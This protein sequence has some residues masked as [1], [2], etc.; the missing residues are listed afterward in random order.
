MASPT[1]SRAPHKAV[2]AYQAQEPDELTLSVGDEVH[3]QQRQEDGWWFGVIVTD[4]APR[5]GLFPGLYVE[6]VVDQA[7]A[8]CLLQARVRG[9][10]ARQR[11]VEVLMVDRKLR[12]LRRRASEELGGLQD[13]AALSQALKEQQ[14]KIMSKAYLQKVFSVCVSDA[15]FKTIDFL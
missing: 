5:C 8:A 6:K 3:V 4:G 12:T 14:Q 2:Y 7:A 10:R 15:M 13:I 1:K 11:V 9:G